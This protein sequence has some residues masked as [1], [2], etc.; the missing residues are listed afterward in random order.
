MWSTCHI[1]KKSINNFD[2]IDDFI[3]LSI[4]RPNKL[5]KP[6]DFKQIKMHRKKHRKENVKM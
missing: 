5:Y 6:Y 4:K 1:Y 2:N 3:M